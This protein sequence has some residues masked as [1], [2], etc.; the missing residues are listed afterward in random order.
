MVHWCFSD[1]T[2]AKWVVGR[3]EKQLKHVLVQHTQP[4]DEVVAIV[5]P[6]RGGLGLY[7]V[8]FNTTA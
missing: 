3:A 1:I 4:E 2:N 6:G 8:H 5:N 7:T